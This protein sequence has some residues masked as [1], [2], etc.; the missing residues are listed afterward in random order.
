MAGS[1]GVFDRELRLRK[2]AAADLRSL[3]SE[4]RVVVLDI[5]YVLGVFALFV[6][7]GL[8]GKA[9]EKL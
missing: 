3:S 7:V 9:V 2:R 6:I 5:V 4:W 8:V 1:R